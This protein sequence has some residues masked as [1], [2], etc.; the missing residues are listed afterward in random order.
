[1]SPFLSVRQYSGQ[2]T[3]EISSR[4]S[5]DPS[6]GRRSGTARDTTSRASPSRGKTRTATGQTPSSGIGVGGGH[7]WLGSGAVDDAENAPPVVF[8]V[9]AIDEDWVKHRGFHGQPVDIARLHPERPESRRRPRV[10]PIRLLVGVLENE[11][12]EMFRRRDLP[13]GVHLGDRTGQRLRSS[14]PARAQSAARQPKKARKRTKCMCQVRKRAASVR[15]VRRRSVPPNAM[16]FNGLRLRITRL[17]ANCKLS[18]L[19]REKKRQDGRESE[20]LQ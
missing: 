12:T 7:G 8:A 5:S 16:I 10:V 4:Q 15:A 11:G 17:G 14:A 1:M 2:S 18:Q 6:P 13:G 9:R 20:G 19:N 3:H